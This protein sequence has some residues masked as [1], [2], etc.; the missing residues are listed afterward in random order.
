MNLKAFILRCEEKWKLGSAQLI[1]DSR[2]RHASLLLVWTTG[3]RG[4]ESCPKMFNMSR[5]CVTEHLLNRSA[6]INPRFSWA[7]FLVLELLTELHVLTAVLLKIL[8]F[9][10]GHHI[11][12]CARADVLKSS[13]LAPSGPK[14]ANT[15]TFCSPRWRQ[16]G[17]LP[18]I[19][20]NTKLSMCGKA[21]LNW[22][23]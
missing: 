14:R 16:R 21:E 9:A 6:V 10:T 22:H 13:L 4:D 12:W 18:A 8:V 3:K 17:I 1:L 20:N 5:H 23:K 15:M 11:N 19:I 2:K 7:L